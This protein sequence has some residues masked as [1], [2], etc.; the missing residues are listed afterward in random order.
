[1]FNN[2]P[3]QYVDLYCFPGLLNDFSETHAIEND[4][5]H[6]HNNPAILSF[7]L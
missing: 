4:F 2:R 5:G 6:R 7:Q 3:N 1:M